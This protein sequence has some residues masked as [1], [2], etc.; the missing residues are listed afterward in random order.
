MLKKFLG[1]VVVLIAGKPYEEFAELL[2]S[3]KYVNEFK[4]AK[5]FGITINQVRNILYK[6][7]DQGLVSSIRKKDKKKGW[8]TYSWK[9]EILKSLKFLDNILIKRINSLKVQ[10]KNR[11]TKKFYVCKKCNLEFNEEDALLQ[12]F[13]CNECGGIFTLKDN[14]KLLRE[15]NRNLEKLTKKLELVKEEIK[16]EEEKIEKQRVKEAKKEEKLKEEQKALKKELRAKARAAKAKDLKK[17][18]KKKLVKKVKKK[19]V[20]KKPIKKVVK[21]K[22]SSKLS[23][24]PTTLGKKKIVKKK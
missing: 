7:S 4:I 5:K 12:N 20:K 15:L 3:K 14:S 16:K 6:I 11:E 13:T 19:S 23:S 1:E 17:K 10:I 21:K 9:I 24:F 18:P 2:S 22:I 8:Y